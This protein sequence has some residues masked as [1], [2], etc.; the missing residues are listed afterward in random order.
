MVYAG[1]DADAAVQDWIIKLSPEVFRR[2]GSRKVH[3]I[4]NGEIIT[5]HFFSDHGAKGCRGL[6]FHSMEVIGYPRMSTKHLVK[7]HVR[8]KELEEIV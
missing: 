2:L 3:A 5:A 7:S 4:K 8:L 1:V 6:A